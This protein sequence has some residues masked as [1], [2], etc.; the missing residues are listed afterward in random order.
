MIPLQTYLIL[1]GLGIYHGI[2][3]A[4]GW[5]LATAVGV[6]RKSRKEMLSS[7]LAL[8][9]GHGV[10]IVLVVFGVGWLQWHLPFYQIRLLTVLALVSFGVYHLVRPWH[11]Y[12]F[13]ADASYFQIGV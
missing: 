13:G 11:P 6:K 2:N 4:M 5:L 3:P 7:L 1:F 9:A 10:A 12:W 8:I